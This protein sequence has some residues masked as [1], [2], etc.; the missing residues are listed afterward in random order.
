MRFAV[1]GVGAIGGFLAGMLAKA[2]NKVTVVARGKTLVAIKK[3]GLT[4]FVDK[5]KFSVVLGVFDPKKVPVTDAV[6]LTVKNYDIKSV[7]E[8][9]NELF[10]KTGFIIPIENGFIADEL[11]KK[12]FP[13]KLASGVIWGPYE[14][15]SPGV[16][17]TYGKRRIDVQA[18]SGVDAIKLGKVVG[19]MNEAGIET[20]VA[21]IKT[22]R[23]KKILWNLVFNQLCTIYNENVGELLKDRKALFVAKKLLKEAASVAKKEGVFLSR[24]HLDSVLRLSYKE[25]G[26]CIPSTYQDFLDGKEL[27]NFSEEIVKKAA[28]YG[29]S[30]PQNTEIMNKIMVLS[31]KK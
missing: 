20:R 11:L 4:F 24:R 23:W 30:V 2:G 5:K 22:V 28:K 1:V 9:Y 21:D 7:L 27:E 12:R 31:A 15:V 10:F 3:N 14:R 26:V 13:E 29:L 18:V 8:E 6:I 19:A 25:F 16:V 17:K